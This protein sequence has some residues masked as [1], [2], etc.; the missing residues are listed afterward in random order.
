MKDTRQKLQSAQEEIQCLTEKLSEQKKRFLEV[1]EII[2]ECTKVTKLVSEKE[3]LKQQVQV[4]VKRIK[5]LWPINC[6]QLS[7]HDNLIFEKKEE[8]KLLQ[9]KLND[10][11]N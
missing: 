4:Q 2:R 10:G 6:Q 3:S 8:M 7:V 9:D 11:A 1:Q 5:E